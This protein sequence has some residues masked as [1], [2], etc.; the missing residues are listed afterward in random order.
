MRDY[1]ISLDEEDFRCIVRG[2]VLT[3]KVKNDVYGG[4]SIKIILKD[5]GFRRMCEA[6]EYATQGVDFRKDH[7]K[8]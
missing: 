2:G 7:E 8:S 4:S 1:F 6:V 3:I 5:I